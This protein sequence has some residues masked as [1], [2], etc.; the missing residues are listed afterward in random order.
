MIKFEINLIN[1]SLDYPLNE[2]ISLCKA[3]LNRNYVQIFKIYKKLPL[4]CQ[5]AFHRRIPEIEM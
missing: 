2:C 3:Y 1:N 5:L 4:L